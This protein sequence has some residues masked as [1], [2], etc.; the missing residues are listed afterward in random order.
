VRKERD[1]FLLPHGPIKIILELTPCRPQTFKHRHPSTQHAPLKNPSRSFP[2]KCGVL[3]ISYPHTGGAF[4]V[5]VVLA[6]REMLRAHDIISAHGGCASDHKGA[7]VISAHGGCA[8]D[9]CR[10]NQPR[11]AE[12]S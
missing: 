7:L 12:C 1:G 11:N 6:N 5:R 10:T 2:A 9:A 8:S 3:M 4:L